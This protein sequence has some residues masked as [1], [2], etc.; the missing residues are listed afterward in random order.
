MI[1]GKVQI[2][3]FKSI[4]DTGSVYLSKGD[5]VTILA[6]QNESGKT[7]FLSALR[8]FE[9]GSYDS[10]EDEDRRMDESPRI[11]CTFYLT[12]EEY[13]KLKTDTNEAIADYVKKNGF[14]FVRGETDGDDFES[15]KWINPD[16]FKTIVA[17]YDKSLNFLEE[18]EEIFFK[19]A[20]S[21]GFL[22][23]VHR[24]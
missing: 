2:Q 21:N 16:E 17:E 19:D 7:S 23:L 10:F 18:G 5:L 11:D 9:E 15:L 8:F 13:V 4:Q 1:L 3:N 22:F 14:T 24:K 6:G 12:E 20:T